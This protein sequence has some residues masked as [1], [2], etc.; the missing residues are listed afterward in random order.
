VLATA[1]QFG[2]RVDEIWI[3]SGPRQEEHWTVVVRDRELREHV[4][5][6]DLEGRLLQRRRR[7]AAQLD[8]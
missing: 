5:A 3:V 2:P 4:V 8:G 7:V 1:L 6:I